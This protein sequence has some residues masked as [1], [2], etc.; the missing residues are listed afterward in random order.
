MKSTGEVMGID[1]DFGRAFAKS[2]IAAGQKLPEKGTVFISVKDR[3][4]RAIIMIAKGLEDL[5]FQIVATQGTAKVLERNG[6]PARHVF[7][8]KEGRPN[9]V[10]LLKNGE[11]QL[12]INTPSGKKPKAD[13]FAIRTAA[14]QHNIPIVTTI[15][16][17]RATVE[18]I[19]ALIKGEIH[20]K[21]LQEYHRHR[22]GP[23]RSRSSPASAP[24]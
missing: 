11:I 13:E 14:V 3:D 20:V 2:Q 12:V 10:D 18:G 16:G 5:G 22:T 4:K 24:K 15:A 19:D 21:S 6:V 23:L 17:A 8:V 7:K 9:V 1:L